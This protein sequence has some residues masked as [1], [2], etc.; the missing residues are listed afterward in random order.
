MA[1]LT[2]YGKGKMKAFNEMKE[3]HKSEIAK[4]NNRVQK[5]KYA[6]LI[7]KGVVGCH[8]KSIDR[9]IKGESNALAKTFGL[10]KKR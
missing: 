2:P 8:Y 4:A 3:W 6:E 7:I 5:D 9:I 1:E 10:N